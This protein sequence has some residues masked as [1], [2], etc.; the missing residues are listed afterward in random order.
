MLDLI[1]NAPRGELAGLAGLTILVALCISFV[2]A[3]RWHLG[4]LA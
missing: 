1:R 3:V 4:L 2:I